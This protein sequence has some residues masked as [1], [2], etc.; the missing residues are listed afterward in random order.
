MAVEPSGDVVGA[1]RSL[2]R[3]PGHGPGPV[4]AVGHLVQLRRERPE[5][6]AGPVLPG[7]GLIRDLFPYLGREVLDLPAGFSGDLAGL[8][9]RAPG[10]VTSGIGCRVPDGTRFLAGAHLGPLV[11]SAQETAHHV[12]QS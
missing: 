5:R 8:F 2:P 1:L 3:H 4:R 9:S 7:T 10:D 6:L 11:L 12:D